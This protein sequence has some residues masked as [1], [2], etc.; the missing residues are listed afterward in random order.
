MTRTKSLFYGANLA[1]AAIVSVAACADPILL[2]VE[3]FKGP[4]QTQDNISGF[5]GA[6]FCTSNAK[7]PDIADTSMDGSATISEAGLYAVWTRGYTSE[8]TNRA[9]QLVVGETRFA[10]THEGSERQWSWQKAGEITLPAGTVA[11]KVVDTADGFESVDAILLTRD[12]TV[13]PDAALQAR[14]RWQVYPHGLP[15]AADPLRFNIEASRDAL[16]LRTDPT[17]AEEW[18]ARAPVIKAALQESLGLA[19]WPEKTPL[20]GKVTGRAERDF[21]FIENIVFESRPDFYVT[22][23]LY[24]PK[25]IS[26]PAPA[27]VV[28]P[29][30][31]M[32][33]GKNYGLYQLGQLG[34]VK[35]GIIVLAYDPIGQGERKL[36]GFKHDLGY[37]SLLVGQSNEGYIVWDSIRAIDYLTTRAEV[38]V[39]KIGLA[40]NSGGGE[41]VFYTMPLDERIQAGTSF[42]FVCSYD[43]WLAEGGN[44][45]ICNHL[46]GIVHEMEEFEIVG[47]NAPRSFLAGN[48]A[49]DKIF[50]VAGHR[51]TIERAQ[52]IYA[53]VGAEGKVAS[54]LA[55][56]G[57][58]W[59]QPLRE[60]GWGW[61]NQWLLG[62]GSG[63]PIPEVGLTAEDVSSVDIKCLK[64]GT[65]PEGAETVVTLNR[66]LAE[67][68]IANYNTPPENKEAWEGRAPQWREEVWAVLGGKPESFKAARRFSKPFEQDGLYVENIVIA[69]E[70]KME[71]GAIFARPIDQEGAKPATIFIG[72]HDDKQAA[73]LTGYAA[74]AVR[75]GPV[76]ILDPRGTGWSYNHTNHLT[77]DSIVL[78]RPLFAQ[79]VWDVMQARSYLAERDDV[80]G[81]RISLHGDGQGGL[82]ALYAAALDGDIAQV[83]ATNVLASYRYFLE[84]EQPQPIALCVPNVL[85][86]IDIPQVAALVAPRPLAVSGVVG[87]GLA[88]LSSEDAA[89]DWAFTTAAYQVAGNEGALH[90]K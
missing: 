48:G 9:Y 58:G 77:S 38:D 84:D 49:K 61:M 14:E 86:V 31:A 80:D 32:E 90:L 44:H 6:G 51:E 64:E 3:D 17:S 50:P 78:G 2:E 72:G 43:L 63:E 83:E 29:G 12:L 16:A 56:E 55:D 89:R 88:G 42:S 24:I 7:D 75:T 11:V 87:Y 60:A 46:P 15:G 22:A 10:P 18:A 28:V 85:K 21:Y 81:A 4:W 34:M 62:K 79:Q 36:P 40:G 74:E 13:A 70:D 41:N 1:V 30:H 82:L 35:E 27:V 23:N 45:C 8:N 52:N 66:Q 5:S 71:V 53:M 19:P 33:D 57:H 37:G 73:V 20:N 54:V 68:F 67:G 25:N 47:L 69:V 65:M 76:L 39:N 59:S 26:A